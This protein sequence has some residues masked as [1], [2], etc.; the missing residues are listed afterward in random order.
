MLELAFRAANLSVLPFWLLMIC[1]PRKDATR[2][3][4]ESPWI[5]A[6]PMLLYVV[7]IA[8]RAVGLLPALARPELSV[9]AKLLATEDGAALAWMHFLTFDLFVGRWIYREA[10][11]RQ[12][13]VWLLAPI[14]TLT[15]LFGP[16]GLLLFLLACLRFPI[17]YFRGR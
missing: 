7:L 12:V 10:L 15:L 13:P 16:A 3:V 2:R 1:F 11:D 8:P 9:I 17:A 14:L 6:V 5:V 4:M